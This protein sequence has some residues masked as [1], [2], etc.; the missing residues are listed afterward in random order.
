MR[1]DAG[2]CRGIS[3]ERMIYSG[4]LFG[5]VR[6]I[7]HPAIFDPNLLSLLTNSL[8]AV[9]QMDSWMAYTGPQSMPGGE[10]LRSPYQLTN[11]LTNIPMI[12]I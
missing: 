7:S 6:A 4:A 1:Y 2:V 12:S 3:P 11:I 10:N 8:D 5:N 9:L